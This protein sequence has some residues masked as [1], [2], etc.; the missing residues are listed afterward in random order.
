MAEN[1]FVD[2]KFAR[3]CKPFLQQ[4]KEKNG[5]PFRLNFRCPYCGDSAKNRFKTRGWIF[6]HKNTLFYKCFN[7]DISPSFSNFLKDMNASLHKDYVME[8]F[9]EDF[10]KKKEPVIIVNDKPKFDIRPHFNLLNVDKVP[11]LP[12]DH[13]AI[14]YLKDRLIPENFFEDIYYSENFFHWVNENLLIKKYESIKFDEPRIIFPIRRE[15]RTIFAISGRTI[16]KSKAPKYITYRHEEAD[17]SK[18]FGLDRLNFDDEILV[19]EGPIDSFFLPNCIAMVGADVILPD[20]MRKDKTTIIFDN[21]RRS[22]EITAR[23]KKYIQMGYKVCLWPENFKFKDINEAILGGL[24]ATQIHSIIVS[25]TH[26]GLAADLAF[27]FW[28]RI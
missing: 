16:Q 13:Q 14:I 25:N 6:E 4:P 9:K 22:K 24:S 27:K 3:L 19:V 7:C 20:K 15:D 12:S 23:I 8:K 2:I 17:D 18:I 5:S 1:V 11:D 10:T 26:Q 28:S 21:E